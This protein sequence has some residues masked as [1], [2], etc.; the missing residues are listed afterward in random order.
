M[1]DT[2]IDVKLFD[3]VEFLPWSDP[4]ATREGI[5]VNFDG[6]GWPR[7]AWTLVRAGRTE[8]P[9]DVIRP[10]RIVRVVKRP[11]DAELYATA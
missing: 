10:G 8:Y 11:T 9:A 5:V 4:L 1:S 7:I 3:T 6:R 2:M